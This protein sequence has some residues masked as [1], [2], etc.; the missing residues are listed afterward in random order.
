MNLEDRK[1]LGSLAA[2]SEN[3]S[4]RTLRGVGYEPEARA[5]R[6]LSTI[7]SEAKRKRGNL[8]FLTICCQKKAPRGLYLAY[9]PS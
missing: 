7:P 6:H 2:N 8:H 9:M 5:G 4:Y 3:P 1:I